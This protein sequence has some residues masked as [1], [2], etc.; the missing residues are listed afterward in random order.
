MLNPRIYLEDCVRH[1][2]H[3]QWRTDFPWQLIYD[4]INNSTFEYSQEDMTTFQQ[5]T[6]YNWDPLKDENLKKINCP[7]CIS[8][9][10]VPW[11]QPPIK[12]GPEAL[13]EYL[14]NDSGFTGSAFQHPCLSCD[15]VITHEKLRVGKY[16]DDAENLIKM[17]RPLAGTILNLWGEPAGTLFRM[18]C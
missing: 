9:N 4:S 6:G 12:A 17:E 8:A 5:S 2:N 14:T 15:L 3:K 16:C 13:E 1:T 11:T 10:R 7:K 18:H